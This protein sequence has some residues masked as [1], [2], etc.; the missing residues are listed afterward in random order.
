MRKNF[1]AQTWLYPMPVLIIGTFDADG[2]PDAMNAAWGGIHDTNQ[3]GVCIDPSHRTAANLQLKKCFTVSVGAAEQA[4]P[5][6]YVGLVSG[7]E[8]PDKVKKAGFHVLRSGFVDA[9]LFEELPFALECRLVSFD[10]ATGCTVGEI[11][12]VSADEKILAADGRISPEKFRPLCF[13]P[14]RHVYRQLG[15]TAGTAFKDGLKLK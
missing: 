12:N 5:C 2:R 1:G 4:V 6:D 11:L 15:E 3:V 13:D 14:V 9:P 7:N 8:E 10:P